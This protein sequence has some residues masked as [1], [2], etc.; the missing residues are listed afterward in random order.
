MKSMNIS[1][2]KSKCISVLKNA[3]E[4][5]E[6]LVVT[7]RGKPLARIEPVTRTSGNRQL[8]IFRGRMKIHG[9]LVHIDTSADW[10]ILK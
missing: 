9:D 5:G 4:T 6:G 1:E 8:G 10:E 2:F 7:L 3:Q